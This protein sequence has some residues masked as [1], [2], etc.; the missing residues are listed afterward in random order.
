MQVIQG[1]GGSPGSRGDDRLSLDDLTLVAISMG[2]GRMAAA[3]ASAGTPSIPSVEAAI[4]LPPAMHPTAAQD[5]REVRRKLDQ[6]AKHVV[7]KLKDL[8]SNNALRGGFDS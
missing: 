3:G 1:Q 2:Q 7:D 6:M 8:K 5:D 4:G